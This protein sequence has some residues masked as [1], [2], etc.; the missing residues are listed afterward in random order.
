MNA[1]GLAG[2]WGFDNCTY[3]VKGG[4]INNKEYYARYSMMG[5]F[6]GIVASLLL[7]TQTLLDS[8]ENERKARSTMSGDALKA[9]LTTEYQTRITLYYNYP[10]NIGDFII[11]TNGSGWVKQLTGADLNDGIIGLCGMIS[12]SAVCASVWKTIK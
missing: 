6:I 8:L 1:V 7:D 4:M 2:Y 10:K 11:A 5:W 9:A 12:G 3:L